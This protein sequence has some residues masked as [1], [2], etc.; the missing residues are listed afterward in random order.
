MNKEKWDSLSDDVQEIIEEINAEWII[1]HGE[2]WDVLDEAGIASFTDA[3]NTVI[4]LDAA[5]DARWKEAVDS[6]MDIYVEG[7]AELG[8]D[9]ASIL[10]YAIERLEDAQK[11]NFRSKYID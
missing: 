4:E 11:G 7:T 5:E 10:E 8:L 2:A 6:V 3:G 9:G 1:K